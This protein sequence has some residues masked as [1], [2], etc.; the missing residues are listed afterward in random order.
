MMALK[1]LEG[2]VSAS[3][4]SSGN[5]YVIVQ[6]CLLQGRGETESSG[7]PFSQVQTDTW[8]SVSISSAKLI[9]PK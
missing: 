8:K 4:A 7:N 9:N 5:W 1:R 2:R 3:I 6:P